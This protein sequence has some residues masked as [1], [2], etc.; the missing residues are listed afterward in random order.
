MVAF[1]STSFGQ[2]L[3]PSN[4]PFVKRA[5]QLGRIGLT[6]EISNEPSPL[7][8]KKAEKGK[9]LSQYIAELSQ[10]HE[11]EAEMIDRDFQSR[12]S[13][14]EKVSKKMKAEDDAA[15]AY[16][17]SLL[18]LYKIQTGTHVS[19]KDFYNVSLQVR[20]AFSGL[21]GSDQQKRDFYEWS[22]STA[23][24]FR[25]FVGPPDQIGEMQKEFAGQLIQE[26]TGAESDAVSFT[27]GKLLIKKKL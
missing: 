7:T 24:T 12:L 6:A 17:Y 1:A 10:G 25:L 18:Y 13:W 8:Y 5:Q 22:L 16:A 26:L 4:N 27:Q 14:L 20:K 19:E 11:E 2:T 15:F 23:L 3:K 21:K 9:F